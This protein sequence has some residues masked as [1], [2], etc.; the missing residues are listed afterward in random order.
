MGNAVTLTDLK[1]EVIGLK[2]VENERIYQAAY[3]SSIFKILKILKI[4]QRAPLYARQP[5]VS[6]RE[7]SLSARGPMMLANEPSVSE[8]GRLVSD[9]GHQGTSCPVS[10]GG[11]PV[12]TK[13]DFLSYVKTEGFSVSA[14][15]LA[16]STR[17]RHSRIWLALTSI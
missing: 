5:P 16:I 14:K 8:M 3:L 15:G 11:P 9:R 17:G 13:L 12:S 2:K 4:G 7:H 1:L 10:A 6:T